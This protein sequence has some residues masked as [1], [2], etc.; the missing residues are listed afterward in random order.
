MENDEA[1]G[2]FLRACYILDKA[3]K[4]VLCEW[5]KKLKFPYGYVLNM[6]RC[7]EMR[8]LKLFGMKSH[9]CHVFMQRLIPIAFRE[10]LPTNV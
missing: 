3:R 9:A 2:K 1:I 8:K 7:V 4:Q 5:V 6:R 10:L